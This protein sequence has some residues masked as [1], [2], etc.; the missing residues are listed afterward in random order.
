M[1]KI[2]GKISMILVLVILANGFISCFS[3][4]AVKDDRT[5]WLFWTIPLDIITLP[6]QLIIFV[7]GVHF[8]I[9]AEN[10]SQTDLAN[11]EDNS[12]TEYSALSEIMLSLPEAE[13]SSIKQTLKS[14]PETEC[15]STIEKLSSLSEANRVSML[16][17]YNSL[18]E[19]EIVSSIKR[20]NSLSKRELISL[21]RNF[22]SL[23]EEEL[24]SLIE[25]L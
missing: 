5:S 25:S 18:P 12:F 23:S 13:I 14:I 1:K 8:S 17:T 19:K 3:T 7:T 20:I 4:M 2:A 9:A 24:N 15:N 21:L 22:N 11:A 16:K 10:G 6:V